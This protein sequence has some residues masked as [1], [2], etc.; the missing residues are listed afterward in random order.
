LGTGGPFGDI[1]QALGLP[2]GLSCPQVGGVSDFLCGGVN[3][4]MDAE[5]RY[6]PSANPQAI[7]DCYHAYQK[8]ESWPTRFF[9]WLSFTSLNEE[10]KKEWEH[11]SLYFPFKAGAFALIKHASKGAGEGAEAAGISATVAATTVDGLGLT[12]CLPTGFT[13]PVPPSVS[14]GH[15][16]F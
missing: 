7:L 6:G 4:I 9:S 14:L 2:S 13:T 12:S 3:P 15:A 1:W 16:T 11:V 10:W 5:P 8:S